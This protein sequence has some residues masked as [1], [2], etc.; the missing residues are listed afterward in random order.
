MLRND[1]CWTVDAESH[2]AVGW[3][4][5]CACEVATEAEPWEVCAALVLLDAGIL[6]GEA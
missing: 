4:R 3:E 6:G 1:E 2:A 5:T